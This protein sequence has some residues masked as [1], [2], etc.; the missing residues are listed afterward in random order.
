MAKCEDNGY[1]LVPTA[2][3]ASLVSVINSS[4]LVPDIKRDLAKFKGISRFQG[5]IDFV[6]HV[7]VQRTLKRSY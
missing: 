3:R 4:R 1:R 2:G 6:V 5:Q 7:L